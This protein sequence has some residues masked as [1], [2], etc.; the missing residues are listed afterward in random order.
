MEEK[1]RKPWD[2]YREGMETESFPQRKLPW[3]GKERGLW[4]PEAGSQA[5]TCRAWG[6]GLGRLLM[7]NTEQKTNLKRLGGP[8]GKC[9]GPET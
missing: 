9:C 2:N 7:Q 1:R 3:P 4:F 6:P 5:L 8:G